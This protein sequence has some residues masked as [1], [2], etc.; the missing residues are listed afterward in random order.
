M[1]QHPVVVVVGVLSTAVTCGN[2]WSASYKVS[3][4]IPVVCMSFAVTPPMY[5]DSWFHRSSWCSLRSNQYFSAASDSWRWLQSENGMNLV[6]PVGGKTFVMRSWTTPRS[7]F[8]VSITNPLVKIS[9]SLCCADNRCALMRIVGGCVVCR[10]CWE[11]WVL[12][13]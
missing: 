8:V 13:V 9:T 10:P 1:L 5:T 3:V 11:R 7:S 6:L 4:C 12:G 2:F